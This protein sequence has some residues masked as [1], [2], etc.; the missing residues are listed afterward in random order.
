M[1]ILK[2]KSSLKGKIALCY[3]FNGNKN[4]ARNLD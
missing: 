3:G 2:N 1:V 4:K